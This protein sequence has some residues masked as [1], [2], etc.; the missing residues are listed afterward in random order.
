MEARAGTYRCLI[1]HT[2]LRSHPLWEGN[3]GGDGMVA[4]HTSSRSAKS[5]SSI[6][7]AAI[8]PGHRQMSPHTAR[9]RPSGQVRH[10]YWTALTLFVR[11][12]HRRK[13]LDRLG[14]ARALL[15]LVSW[16]RESHADRRR[17]SPHRGQS[18]EDRVVPSAE[19]RRRDV[20]RST[21][22]LTGSTPVLL[23]CRHLRRT[24]GSAARS[25]RSAVALP[26]G[27]IT[28]RSA[29]VP[30]AGRLPGVHPYA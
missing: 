21:S 19:D 29:Q 22:R 23:P 26:G 1:C 8:S 11:R 30:I 17:V 16:Q 25:W 9:R 7:A 28:R 5:I 15:A 13:S 4:A 2:I 6:P 14:A 3:S 24:R 10:R 12:Y 27:A 18:H 20:V